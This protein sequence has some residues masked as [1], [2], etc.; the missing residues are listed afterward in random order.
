MG[1]FKGMFIIIDGLD[2]SGK[3]TQAMRLLRFLRNNGKTVFLRIHPSNDNFFGKNAKKFLY[4]EGINAHFVSAI[5][6]MLY[7]FRI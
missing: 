1:L 6:Y 7:V 3:S 2:G 5:F 4:S